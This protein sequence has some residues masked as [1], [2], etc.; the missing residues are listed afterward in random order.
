M[1]KTV[2]TLT[3]PLQ[4]AGRADEGIAIPAQVGPL[5]CFIVAGSVEEAKRIADMVGSPAVTR[6]WFR[7]VL[8][9]RIRLQLIS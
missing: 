5:A 7:C 9:N 2:T 1:T 8:I 4:F 3:P 6:E